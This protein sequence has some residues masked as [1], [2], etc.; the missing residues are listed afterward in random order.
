MEGYTSREAFGF[1]ISV[2]SSTIRPTT[3]KELVVTALQ[4]I[5]TPSFITVDMFALV[6]PYLFAFLLHSSITMMTA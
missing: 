2:L 1:A 6:V 5:L 4:N 3:L